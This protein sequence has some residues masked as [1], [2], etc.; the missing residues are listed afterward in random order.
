[1]VISRVMQS[2][3]RTSRL[4]SNA[5]AGANSAYTGLTTFYLC[6][7]SGEALAVRS[8]I[9]SFGGSMLQFPLAFSAISNVKICCR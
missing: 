4:T 6:N 1:M 5:I 7:L 3:I 2:F 9:S 8:F